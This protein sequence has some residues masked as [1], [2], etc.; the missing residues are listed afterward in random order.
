[1]PTTEIS[2]GS[3]TATRAMGAFRSIRGSRRFRSGIPAT[4]SLTYVRRAD[5]Q[6][7]QM[8]VS[9]AERRQNRLGHVAQRPTRLLAGPAQARER[10][11]L[12]E[13]VLL[14]QQALRAL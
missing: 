6:H 7:D 2:L 10:L 4:S 13:P 3:Q 1:M 8:T 5:C 12:V 11:P 9:I 14:H